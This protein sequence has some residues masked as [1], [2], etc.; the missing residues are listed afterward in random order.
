MAWSIKVVLQLEQRFSNLRPS[1]VFFYCGPTLEGQT[2]ISSY[3]IT[4]KVA[5]LYEVVERSCEVAHI[6]I[7]FEAQVLSFI[8]LVTHNFVKMVHNAS[9]LESFEMKSRNSKR[10]PATYTRTHQSRLQNRKRNSIDKFPYS[11]TNYLGWSIW[12][13]Q[14]DKE[15]GAH[16]QTLKQIV[17]G[18]VIRVEMAQPREEWANKSK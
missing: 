10:S 11:V 17:K 1:H 8:K 18:G 2:R 16:T 4:P 15:S 13:R 12:L 6:G 14:S 9:E 5:V 3:T 7:Q